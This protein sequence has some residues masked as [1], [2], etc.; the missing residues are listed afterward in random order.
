[1]LFTPLLLLALTGFAFLADDHF[2]NVFD[3][4]ALIRF[5]RT[6]LAD[7]CGKLSNLLFVSAVDNDFVGAG[8]SMVMP[9]ISGM[10]T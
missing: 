10:M 3:A 7:L 9:S 2:V 5:R 6:F 4:L 8:T 1:M